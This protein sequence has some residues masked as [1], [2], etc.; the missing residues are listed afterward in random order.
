MNTHILIPIK[1]IQDRI[2]KL[3]S[4]N[5]YDEWSEGVQF[6]RVDALENLLTDYKQISLDNYIEVLDECKDQLNTWSGFGQWNRNDK[7]VIEKVNSFI[8][9]LL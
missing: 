3:K 8:K 1:S 7:K 4:E 5:G 2:K 6:G 9:D